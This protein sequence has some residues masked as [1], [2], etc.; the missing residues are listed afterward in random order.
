MTVPVFP[1]SDWERVRVSL[2]LWPP[3]TTGNISPVSQCW[4][5]LSSRGFN[6]RVNHLL[7]HS[8]SDCLQRKHSL[9]YKH[10]F[11][12]RK[13][14][15]TSNSLIFTVLIRLL[16]LTCSCSFVTLH[17][18]RVESNC[19]HQGQIIFYFHWW[20]LWSI[21]CQKTVNHINIT[22]YQNWLREESWLIHYLSYLFIHYHITD[23]RNKDR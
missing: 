7:Y 5:G 15:P 17:I 21:K 18:L 16:F 12:S 9:F 1:T 19:S 10:L 13:N 22:V 6:Y 2:D 8:D 14:S 3:E 23:K 11:T 4:G 20:F